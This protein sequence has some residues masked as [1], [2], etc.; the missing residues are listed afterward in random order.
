MS[1]LV[2][3]R[4]PF[5]RRYRTYPVSITGYLLPPESDT[6]FLR[7]VDSP[8]DHLLSQ[9]VLPLL[10]QIEPGTPISSVENMLFIAVCQYQE[11]A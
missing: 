4:V 7:R 11:R 3:T 1:I 9:F 6:A 2:H 10:I 8:P 5:T